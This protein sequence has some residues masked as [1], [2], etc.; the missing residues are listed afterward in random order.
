MMVVQGFSRGKSAQHNGLRK[1]IM[2]DNYEAVRVGGL[3]QEHGVEE[4]GEAEVHDGLVGS[5]CFGKERR[6]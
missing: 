2:F 5:L 3:T 6:S 4:S 1:F